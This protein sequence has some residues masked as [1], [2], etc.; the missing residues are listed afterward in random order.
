[1]YDNLTSVGGGQRGYNIRC[2][3]TE[4]LSEVY[5]SL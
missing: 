1:M 4:R 3:K 5:M 2:P